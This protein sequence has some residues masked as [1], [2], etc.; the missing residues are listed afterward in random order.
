[1]PKRQA[2]PTLSCRTGRRSL[3]FEGHLFYRNLEKAGISPDTCRAGNENILFREPTIR[4]D[5]GGAREYAR[6]DKA[7]AIHP[8]AALMSASY[9]MFQIPGERYAECGFDNIEAFVAAQNESVCRQLE[10]LCTLLQTQG[11]I[12]LL[13]AH[14]WPAFSHRVYR[15][16]SRA[17][18]SGMENGTGTITVIPR[19]TATVRDTASVFMTAVQ[20]CERNIPDGNKYAHSGSCRFCHGKTGF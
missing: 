5:E 6:L 9:G 20:E 16:V 18:R 2:K 11:T 14:D 15:L 4:Y 17:G 3:F 13:R 1:M 12:P 8:E 10:T 7:R 19:A